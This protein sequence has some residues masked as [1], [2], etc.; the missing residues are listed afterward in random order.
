[1]GGGSNFFRHVSLHQL[2]GIWKGLLVLLKVHLHFQVNATVNN[3]T[4]ISNFLPQL[5]T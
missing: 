3:F 5:G 4:P 1:M 2:V